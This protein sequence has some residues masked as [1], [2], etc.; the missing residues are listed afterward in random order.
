MDRY[1]PS[2]AS[3]A[4]SATGNG[5]QWPT[6]WTDRA[7]WTVEDAAQLL[8][9]H[10]DTLY[11]ACASGDFP[12]SRWGG[13]GDSWFVR[14]PC[15]ALRLRLRPEVRERTYNTYGDTAQLELPLDVSCLIPVR[16]FRN[17]RELIEPFHYESALWGGRVKR[18]PDAPSEASGADLTA[19]E[20]TDAQ[21][22]HAV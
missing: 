20:K 21:L 9:V 6:V 8:R 17:T 5:S 3:S 15:E 19:Y 18:V 14:I 4:A 12:C 13:S 16:R 1:G 22:P 7:W 10:T 2:E 11:D